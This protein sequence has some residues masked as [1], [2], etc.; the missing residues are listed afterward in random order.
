VIKIGDNP[1]TSPG[2]NVTVQTTS[3]DARVTFPTVSQTGNTTFTPINPPSSAGSP[4]SGYTILGSG[5]AYDITTTAV[6]TPP[7]TVCFNVSTITSEAEFARVRILHGENGQ[8]VDRTIL[9][10][11]APAPDFATRRVCARVNSLSPFVTALAPAST[12]TSTLQLD[13]PSYDISE[14][15][16]SLA[17]LV[18]RSGD[19]SLPVAVDYST[20]DT[21]AFLQNCNV[22]NG[23]A[24]SR[25]DYV[26][27]LGTLHFAAGESSKTISIPIVD[28][29]YA[30]GAETFSIALSHP[31]GGAVLG[32]N[33]TA[34]IHITDNS[35][36]G[37]GQPN[38][39]DGK[40]FFV[41]QHYIDFLSREPDPLSAGWVSILDGC[42]PGDQSCRLTVSQ[43]IYNSPEFKDR[44]YFIYKF[45]SVALG[46]KPSYDEFNVDRARV[47]GFQTEAELEQSKVDFITDFMGRTEFT[48]AYNGLSN[49]QYVQQLYFTAGVQQVTVGG[50][51][52]TLSDEQQRLNADTISRA[53]VLRDIAE[54]PEVS[55]K[56]LVEATVVMHYFG[57]LRRD[58]DAFYQDWITILNQTGDSRNVTNG[59]VNSLEYRARFGAP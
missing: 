32:A 1:N 45:Y 7:V 56:Y 35:N 9:A 29:S 57:Y 31:T 44:G 34:P 2:N 18:N 30:E 10:P 55:A 27:V 41:R 33:R 39:I 17:V 23:A 14:G 20:S 6:Y 53:Q 59:F 48:S 21:A 50:V 40:T 24:T 28:D 47:S 8:L 3:G 49:N 46:R 12:P 51:V 11:D 26:G 38:P 4:P 54:S 5:P 43:G 52:R 13:K 37:T 25:C 15:A 36:D 22:T 16:G 58:P 19:L 42:A